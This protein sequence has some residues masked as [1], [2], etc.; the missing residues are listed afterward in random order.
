MT[1]KNQH[2]VAACCK[3]VWT[4]YTSKHFAGSRSLCYKKA[5][6][7]YFVEDVGNVVI[8]TLIRIETTKEIAEG[9]T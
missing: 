7:N 9:N 5:T 6:F 2:K 1:D 4:S 8:T 3:L